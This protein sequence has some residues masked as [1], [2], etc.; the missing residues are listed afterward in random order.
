MGIPQVRE[1]DVRQQGP[2]MEGTKAVTTISVRSQANT[3]G[4]G[5]NGTSKASDAALSSY[6]SHE[7][8]IGGNASIFQSH[9]NNSTTAGQIEGQLPPQP[10]A[11]NV[12]GLETGAPIASIGVTS[13]S[14]VGD[15]EK[16]LQTIYQKEMQGRSAT[17]SV[18]YNNDNTLNG[19]TLR[20]SNQSTV[21]GS[22]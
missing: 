4:T 1:L 15:Q 18:E 3:S 19:E 22:S 11:S 2:E 20:I 14:N 17:N 8:P 9:G 21:T 16:E 12:E 10:T 5:V 7:P 6:I 13:T